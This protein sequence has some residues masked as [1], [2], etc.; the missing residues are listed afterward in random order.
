MRIV[1]V[2]KG[3]R[4]RYLLISLAAINAFGRVHRKP[5][6]GEA[7]RSGADRLWPK[8]SANSIMN[9][10]RHQSSPGGR[11]VVTRETHKLTR[12]GCDRRAKSQCSAAG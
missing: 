3:D 8:H 9:R 6:T 5:P 11:P 7:V 10:R 2:N 1:K 4:R 12:I